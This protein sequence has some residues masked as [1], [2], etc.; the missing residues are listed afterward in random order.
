MTTRQFPKYTMR[1]VVFK[2]GESASSISG[3]SF[4]RVLLKFI[5][6]VF[7]MPIVFAVAY[8]VGGDIML[9]LL[10]V[11]VVGAMGYLVLSIFR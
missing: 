8:L 2:P 5:L 1:N 7:V 3:G 6:Y 11:L 10:T 9:A 4:G